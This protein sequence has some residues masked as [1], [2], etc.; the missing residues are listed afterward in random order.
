MVICEFFVA[1]QGIIKTFTRQ[2]SEWLGGKSLEHQ[3]F[4]NDSFASRVQAL[5]KLAGNKEKLAKISDISATMVSK[6]SEGKSEP[7]RDKLVAMA[8][9]TGV[10]VL[11]LATGEG[12]IMKGK[13]GI[14]KEEAQHDRLAANLKER[15]AAPTGDGGRSPV[16]A[17]AVAYID[18]M[19]D[20]EAAEIVKIIIERHDNPLLTL[21]P[22]GKAE[23]RAILEERIKAMEAE[24]LN[25]IGHVD[26][27]LTGT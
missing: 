19:P 1:I 6:Y 20:A 23:V 7:A 21:S 4:P 13:V 9:A 18:A 27:K 15:T 10:N 26:H 3:D 24:E 22:E 14:E 11:W 8:I 2:I 17:A 16:K 25:E 5:I 12:P